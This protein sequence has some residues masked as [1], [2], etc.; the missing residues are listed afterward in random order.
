MRQRNL[1]KRTKMFKIL[2]TCLAAWP[3]VRI[4]F[5]AKE[6][7]WVFPYKFC[8]YFIGRGFANRAKSWIQLRTNTVHYQASFL[9][10]RSVLSLKAHRSPCFRRGWRKEKLFTRKVWGLRWPW[11]S[12]QR[13]P[14]HRFMFF[15]SIL[16]AK[17]VWGMKTRRF[18]QQR[19]IFTWRSTLIGHNYHELP[20]CWTD[21][22][23]QIGSK[24]HVLCRHDLHYIT[25]HYF[26][27]L[28]TLQRFWD[29]FRIYR[30][31]RGSIICRLVRSSGL[32]EGLTRWQL[33]LAHVKCLA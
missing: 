12:I 24:H 6:K 13:P 27:L 21:S 5:H 31:S 1:S 22:A 9:N 16:S 20:T 7:A 3:H 17:E 25:L 29:F 26:T 28:Y 30:S 15:L 18:G 10:P 14:K 23:E 32:P 33:Y 2:Q 4:N 19:N 11:S 8:S